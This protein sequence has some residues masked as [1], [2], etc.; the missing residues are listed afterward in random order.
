MP[1]ASPDPLP[2]FRAFYNLVPWPGIGEPQWVLEQ[3]CEDMRALVGLA[4]PIVGVS[5]EDWGLVW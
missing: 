4:G 1:D 3:G 2:A 5:V